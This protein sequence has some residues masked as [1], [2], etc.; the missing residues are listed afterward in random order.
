[1]LPARW[2]FAAHSSYIF[3]IP[4][5]AVGADCVTVGQART[6]TSRTEYRFLNSFLSS[7]NTS[8]Y[9]ELTQICCQ[10]DSDWNRTLCNS[11]ELSALSVSIL[12][13]LFLYIQLSLELE[14]YV[15]M[16]SDIQ[17]RLSSG[18]G[19]VVTFV[20]LVTLFTQFP[21]LMFR[22]DRHCP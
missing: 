9:G 4:P 7:R 20:K 17:G 11:T 19:Y 3:C 8:R 10:A 14:S 18:S 21:V 2:R 12:F 15:M 22:L 6:A 13:F 5:P 16:F 1:M